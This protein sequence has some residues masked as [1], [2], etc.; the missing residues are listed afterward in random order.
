MIDIGK[1]LIIFIVFLFLP[2]FLYLESYFTKDR[3]SHIFI[4]IF[5]SLAFFIYLSFII[6]II[7]LP[8]QITILFVYLVIFL[9]NLRGVKKIVKIKIPYPTKKHL[10]IA[11]LFIFIVMSLSIWNFQSR[12]ENGAL[13]AVSYHDS[14]WHISIINEINKAF[15]PLNPGYAGETLKNYHYLYDLLISSVFLLTGIPVFNLY[16]YF[17]SIFSAIMYLIGIY[18]LISIFTKETFFRVF[19]IVLTVFTGNLSYLLPFISSQYHFITSPNVFMSDQPFDQSLNPFNLLAY[20]M[21]LTLFYLFYLIVKKPDLG[22]KWRVIISFAILGGILPGIKIYA[23]MLIFAGLL[24]TLILSLIIYRKVLLFILIPYCI[25]LPI[26]LLGKGKS[27]TTIVYAPF[28]ILDRL[29]SDSNRLNWPDIVLKEQYYR[30]IGNYLGLF[31]FK[32]QQ[33]LIYLLGNMNIRLLG[34]LYFIKKTVWEDITFNIF[35]FSVILASIIIPL[36]FNQSRNPYDIIQFNHYNLILLSII[37]IPVI[38]RIVNILSIKWSKEIG[39]LLII[40]ILFVAI[41]SSVEVLF[42]RLNKIT[43]TISKD[44]VEGLKYLK[45]VSKSTDIVL[46]DPTDIKLWIMYIPALSERV[47]F[48]AAEGLVKQTG[49]DTKERREQIDLLFPKAGC[50]DPT[51]FIYSNNISYIYLSNKRLDHYDCFNKENL[52]T[53][54]KNNTVVIKKVLR[55]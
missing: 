46:N 44:E 11:S 13:N 35:L 1:F 53:I 36:L 16:F 22:N 52:P 32:F 54:Y 42:V 3:L 50:K 8:Y 25:F 4:S 9:L 26:Y 10:L 28:W 39:Y 29:I 45:N 21:F 51:D 31:K 23:G 20:G 27:P 19:G 43:S 17:F 41:P 6:R 33:L 49:V 24:V 7:G 40:M 48:L 12:E 47:S 5:V 30:E 37:S 34:F 18:L 38:E 15:P 55:N 2:G 14:L